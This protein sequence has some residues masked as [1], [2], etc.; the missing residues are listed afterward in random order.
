MGNAYSIDIRKCVRKDV[1]VRAVDRRVRRI[2][3]ILPVKP[4]ELILYRDIDLKTESTGVNKS[5]S[6]TPFTAMLLLVLLRLYAQTA[7]LQCTHFP[8]F[9]CSFCIFG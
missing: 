8:Y 7:Y 6:H 9:F 3:I 4:V 5:F 2:V 1:D